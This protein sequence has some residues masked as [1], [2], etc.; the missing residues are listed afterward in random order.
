MCSTSLLLL[1]LAFGSQFW[2][3]TAWDITPPKH[4]VTFGDSYAAGMGTGVAYLKPECRIGLNNYGDILDDS[5]GSHRIQHRECSGDTTAKL[6][7]RIDEWETPHL[8]DTALIT[9]GANDLRLGDLIQQCIL[10]DA[11]LNNATTAQAS[12]FKAKWTARNLFADD[13]E[14]GI[15]KRL[16]NAFVKILNKSGRETFQIYVTGYPTFFNNET[17]HCNNL[18]FF[19]PAWGSL[20]LGIKTLSTE[21]RTEMNKV[22]LGL[23]TVIKAAIDE[24][25]SENKRELPKVHFADVDA[26]FQGHRFCEPENKETDPK[27]LSTY[28]FLSGWPDIDHK[29]KE[30][31][32]TES[33]KTKLEKTMI[34]EEQERQDLAKNGKIGLP[35]AGKCRAELDADSDPV[36]VWNCSMAELVTA[37]PDG[38]AAQ[39]LKNA[40]KALAKGDSEASDIAWWLPTSQIKTFQ[41]RSIGMEKFSDAIALAIIQDLTRK[42]VVDHGPYDVKAQNCYSENKGVSASSADVIKGADLFCNEVPKKKKPVGEVSTYGYPVDKP[43]LSY[44][45]WGVRGCIESSEQSTQNPTET[46]GGINCTNLL[47]NNIRN[48]KSQQ[49][50]GNHSTYLQSGNR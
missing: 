6:D 3:I 26:R 13:S 14:N 5:V 9:T 19:N 43:L 34:Q 15:K 35:D 17:E 12:C 46:K 31:K 23:N 16:K 45:V 32:T 33:A 4:L 41:V 2:C 36:A 27:N 7:K 40:N 25:N 30:I 24:Y 39:S 48:C 44:D 49:Q 22:V 1:C 20:D 47:Q 11:I 10:A 18:P 29:T 42:V 38:P 21:L 37:S 8:Y 50:K 28:F